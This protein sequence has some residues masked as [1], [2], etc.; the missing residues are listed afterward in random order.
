MIKV[1]NGDICPRFDRMMDTQYCDGCS[2]KH[3][4][5]L[6]SDTQDSVIHCSFEKPI[7]TAAAALLLPPPPP[8]I[9][10]QDM[11]IER[12]DKIIA[13]F[14]ANSMRHQ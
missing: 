4:Y 1:H 5:N 6:D 12:L 10:K 3:H 9:D 2:F 13:L 11:I 14:E 8:P 7:S